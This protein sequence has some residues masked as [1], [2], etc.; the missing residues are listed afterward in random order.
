MTSCG[1]REAEEARDNHLNRAG[2]PLFAVEL[3]FVPQIGQNN[4][5]T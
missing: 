4:I 5:Y 1:C 3:V 2:L